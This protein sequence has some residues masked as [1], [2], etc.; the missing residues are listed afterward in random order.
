MSRSSEEGSILKGLAWHFSWCPPPQVNRT[1]QELAVLKDIQEVWGALGPQLFNFLNDSRNTAMLQVGPG[2]RLAD[3]PMASLGSSSL[4]KMWA[5][6]R[7]GS[8]EQVCGG[9]SWS[10]G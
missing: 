2:R 10:P 7:A 1:F 4:P 8:P 3:S 6:R 5:K 9:G